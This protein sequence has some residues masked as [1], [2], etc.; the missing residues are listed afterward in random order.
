M[1]HDPD[2]A[3][4]RSRMASHG[5][6]GK[7]HTET[8]AVKKLTDKVLEGE[9]L[10]PVAHAVVALQNIKLRSIELERKIKETEELEAR[11]QVL[12]QEY[13]PE[14]NQRPRFGPH[15]RGVGR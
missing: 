13:L 6:R 2:K 1:G 9:I 15:R 7:V 5:G 10:P 11:L 8:R 4:E 14:Q 3:T 12:E